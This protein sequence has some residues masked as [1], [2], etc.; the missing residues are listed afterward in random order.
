MIPCV[1]LQVSRD[2]VSRAVPAKRIGI[3]RVAETTAHVVE[4]E[5]DRGSR[6]GC[7]A[8]K[9]AHPDPATNRASGPR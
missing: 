6:G 9:W 8:R 4:K 7:H 1:D 3:A 5:I 2:V